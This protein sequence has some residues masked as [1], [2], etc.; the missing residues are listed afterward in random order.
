MRNYFSIIAFSFLVNF[1]VVIEASAKCNIEQFRFG[2]TV[3]DIE[4]QTTN[5]QI[6][7]L[8]SSELYDSKEDKYSIFFAGE[9]ICKNDDV[10]IGAPVEMVFLYGKLVELRLVRF[11]EKEDAP[12]LINW[13]EKVYGKKD[14]KPKGYDFREPD[15]HLVWNNFNATVSYSRTSL[16]Y[17]TEELV[18]IQSRRFGKLFEK[19]SKKTEEP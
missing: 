7:T 2:S 18:V 5:M 13:A 16:G 1:L 3:K 19:Y 6:I 8:P 12:V 14:N 10:F 11:L 9:D 15:M 4:K 17:G